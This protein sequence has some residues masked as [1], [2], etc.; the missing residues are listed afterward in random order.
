MIFI[1]QFLIYEGNTKKDDRKKSEVSASLQNEPAVY[2]IWVLFSSWLLLIE[3]ADSGR[4][5]DHSCVL[6]NLKN[7]KTRFS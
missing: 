3:N 4:N 5:P 6:K 2:S 7:A 1:T